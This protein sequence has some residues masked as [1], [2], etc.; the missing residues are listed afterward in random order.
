M[1]SRAP[2]HPHLGSSPHIRLQLTSPGLVQLVL[3]E[4]EP[5]SVDGA[6]VELDSEHE[7][8]VCP[9][10]TLVIAGHLDEGRET[11]G[12]A[13]LSTCVS[14][15]LPPWG[16][17]GRSSARASTSRWPLPP[18]RG[19]AFHPPICLELMS[20]QRLCSRQDTPPPLGPLPLPRMV[21]SP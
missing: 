15:V 16:L 1:R 7:G 8:P 12:Q 4:G 14:S 10:A 9:P 6:R 18:S 5:W 17:S 2:A 20:P 13:L 21:P 19:L 11:R 3:R